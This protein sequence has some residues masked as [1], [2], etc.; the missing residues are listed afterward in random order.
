VPAFDPG[1]VDARRNDEAL[2]ALAL[3]CRKSSFDR[4]AL[5]RDVAALGIV[6]A[7]GERR[8]RGRGRECE[9]QRALRGEHHRE[10]GGT[11]R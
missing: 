9:Q 6:A 3:A 5:G 8:A 4:R 2:P 11:F 10:R 1:L 7:G